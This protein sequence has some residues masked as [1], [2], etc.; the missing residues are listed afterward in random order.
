MR[1]IKNILTKKEK[2]F[3]ENHGI[4]AFLY[5]DDIYPVYYG[6]RRIY[7]ST[8]LRKQIVRFKESKL[9]NVEVSN[10]APRGG[11]VGEVH[12][13]RPIKTR[14]KFKAIYGRFRRLA[15]FIEKRNEREKAEKEAAEKKRSKLIAEKWANDADNLR[16]YNEIEAKSS[17]NSHQRSCTAS[18][19]ISNNLHISPSI[20]R[21]A[22][23]EQRLKATGMGLC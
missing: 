2:Q 7:N 19:K 14:S 20:L 6:N 4:S 8:K 9:F 10:D 18:W 17:G 5:G 3:I 11:K 12:I 16:R 23:E 22:V 13:F 1:T 21:H 15:I